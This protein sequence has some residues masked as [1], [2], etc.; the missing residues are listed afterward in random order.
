MISHPQRNQNTPL[1]EQPTP[2]LPTLWTQ[3]NRLARA[4][5]LEVLG[6]ALHAL[7]TGVPVFEVMPR[8]D[9]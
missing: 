1:T 4:N 8:D 5:G 9:S 2:G 6:P 3:V 7:P